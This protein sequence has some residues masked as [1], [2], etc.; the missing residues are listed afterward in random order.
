MVGKTI[1][2]FLSSK[3][4]DCIVS[5]PNRRDLDLTNGEA[6]KRFLLANQ[7]DV[8]VHCA[9]R[10]GG[11]QA[12]IDDPVGFLSDN[13]LINLHVIRGAA[14]RG[15]RELI[16]LGSSC[17]YPRD[18]INP[19]REEFILAAPLEPTNE[20]YALGKILGAKLCEYYASQKGLHYRT[21]VP[22]NLYGP[23]D[24]F[25]PENG[26]LIASLL[27]KLH[28]AKEN[29]TGTVEVWGDGTAQREFLFVGDLAE[30]VCRWLG[31]AECLPQFLNVGY[32]ADFSVRE[33]YEMGVEIVGFKG[34]L[35]FDP[36]KPKGMA[37]KLIDSSRAECF[38][39]SPK[40]HLR[41]GMEQTYGYFLG[42]LKE[43]R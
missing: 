15:I 13:A 34:S 30:F 29:G 31:K 32:G 35:A 38:G 20:G 17:M 21:L 4:P 16:Y 3:R 19:L 12:N 33:Y 43:A 42:Q 39:W 25:D 5:A 10:V 2:A 6:V 22:C 18:Y 14:E 9:G 24:H 8:V 28:F 27:Y 26:H 40:T 11:I 7:F 36:T 41:Q 23:Y 37:K 1:Q